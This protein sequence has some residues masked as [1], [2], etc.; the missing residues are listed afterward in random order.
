MAYLSKANIISIHDNIV[1]WRKILKTLRS[2]VHPKDISM[3]NMS[4]I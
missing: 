2:D 3:P 4:T 1:T